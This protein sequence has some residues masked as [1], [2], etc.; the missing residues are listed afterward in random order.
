MST[1]RHPSGPSSDGE[2]PLRIQEVAAEVGL[3]TR[4]IRYYEEVG[5]LAPARS[6]G[7][8]RLYD[9]DDLER[10]RFIKA[11]RDD[12]GFSLAEIGQLL[13]DEAARVRNREAFKASDDPV[14]RRAILLEGIGRIDRQIASLQVKIVRIRAMIGE[15]RTRR[16]HLAERVE[17]LD[18]G[19]Q[20]S[21]V[22]VESSRSRREGSAGT[23][24]H[25][26][27]GRSRVADEDR[28]GESAAR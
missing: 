11:L 25:A 19:E 12:A 5:L 14:E 27:I 9:T 8:Y 28:T 2:R 13:E 6:G 16:S 23:A 4:S 24:D 22:H 20:R 15:A 3:T 18:G 1:Q 21:H 7:D 17:R 10:L 26:A